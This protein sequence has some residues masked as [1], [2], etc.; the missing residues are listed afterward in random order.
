MAGVS[1]PKRGWEAS[2]GA[3]D[4]LTFLEVLVVLFFVG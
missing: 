2:L 4:P 1:E 3:W